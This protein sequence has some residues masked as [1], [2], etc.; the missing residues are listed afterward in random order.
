MRF[1][2]C[3]FLSLVGLATSRTI[4]NDKIQRT[5]TTISS[6]SS[7]VLKEFGCE[8][9]YEGKDFRKKVSNVWWKI[10]QEE[11]SAWISLANNTIAQGLKFF[12]EVTTFGII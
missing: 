7:M 6:A 10:I 12:K 9:D 1:Q 4:Q 8:L 5:I 3:L 11:K 2:L